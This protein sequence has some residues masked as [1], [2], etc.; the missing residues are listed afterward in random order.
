MCTLPASGHVL[1]YFHAGRAKPFSCRA[2]C[3]VPLFCCLCSPR[4]LHQ[5]CPRPPSQ[6]GPADT[7]LCCCQN[8]SPR[9]GLRAPALP[10]AGSRQHNGLQCPCQD[11][12]TL[13]RAAGITIPTA[14]SH[15]VISYLQ[16]QF[17]VTENIPVC[18]CSSRR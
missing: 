18:G 15:L 13:K 4:S 10:H 6:G 12:G 9:A 16:K 2:R 14:R 8:L 17:K 1:N 3:P 11:P 5:P 7:N